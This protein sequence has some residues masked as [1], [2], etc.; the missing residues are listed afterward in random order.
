MANSG[1][2]DRD[3]VKRYDRRAIT[4]AENG[5]RAWGRHLETQIRELADSTKDERLR[6]EALRYLFDRHAGND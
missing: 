5:R 6:F 1:S 3:T 2:S 4:S